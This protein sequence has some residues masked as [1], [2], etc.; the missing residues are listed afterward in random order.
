[1]IPRGDLRWTATS[2]IWRWRQQGRDDPLRCGVPI[3]TIEDPRDTRLAPYA[4]VREPALLSDRGLLIAEGRYIVR[5]LL[6]SGRVRILSLLLNPAAAQ[7]LGEAIDAADFDVDVLVAS[8]T[9]IAGATGFNMHHGCLALAERPAP[10]AFDT[11]VAASDVIVV[12]ERVADPDNIGSVFR[13]AEAFGADAV[14]LSPGCGD[15]YYRKAIRTSSGAA[16]TVPF[17]T[18]APWPDALDRLRAAGF[19]LAALT[20]AP[21]AADLGDFVRSESVRGRVAV[22]F[23]TEGRGLTEQA[24]A[25]ADVRLRIPISRASDSLNIATAA[26]ITLHR[27]D[28]ARRQAP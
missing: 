27:L 16:L 5:R 17:A 26:G 22:L 9:V 24:L 14:L 18:A 8:P 7:G 21:G 15:P 10:V 4:G 3:I 20:P 1:M 6:A 11:V 25:R 2:T 19:T 13:N 23:G 12:L 28:D